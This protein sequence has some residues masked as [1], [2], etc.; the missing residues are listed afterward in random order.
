MR[1]KIKVTTTTGIKFFKVHP[2]IYDIFKWHWEHQR[3]FKIANCVMKHDEILDIELL[4]FE[5]EE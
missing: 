4:E 5:V 3:D 1:V 2:A